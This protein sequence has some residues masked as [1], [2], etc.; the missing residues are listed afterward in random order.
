[1]ASAL[2]ILG[3]MMQGG[4]EGVRENAHRSIA[5]KEKQADEQR[6]DDRL[7]ARTADERTYNEGVYD[8]T[9]ADKLTDDEAQRKHDI[10]LANIRAKASRSSSRSNTLLTNRVKAFETAGTKYLE[11]IDKISGDSMM[12]PEQKVSATAPLYARLDELVENNQDMG[13][14]SPLYGSFFSS[15]KSFLSQFD[16]PEDQEA[17]VPPAA[18]NT[19]NQSF[20]IPVKRTSSDTTDVAPSNTNQA[21]VSKTESEYL[22]RSPQFI[23]QVGGLLERIKAK[24]GQSNRTVDLETLRQSGNVRPF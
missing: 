3:S 11:A 6:A 10:E 13:E 5:D 4:G 17:S 2:G 18:S 8:K 22:Q 7:K 20:V 12:T 1:M 9:R 21:T 24:P 15:A 19:Q 14:L 16:K 23:Q